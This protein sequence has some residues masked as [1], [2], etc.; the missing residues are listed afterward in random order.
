MENLL[1]KTGLRI[2]A[3]YETPF[4]NENGIYQD[5]TV[6]FCRDRKGKLWAIAGHSH[7]GHIGMFCG[8][9]LTDLREVYPISLNFCVGHADYAFDRIP[10]PEGVKARGSIWPFGLYLCPGTGRFFCFFHNETGWNGKSTAYD[11]LGPCETPHFDSDFRHIGLMHSDDEGATWTFDRWIL[12][13]EEACFTEKYNPGAG[14]ALG[15]REGVIGLGSGD[16]TVYDDLDGEYLYLLYNLIHVD[17]RGGVW[18]SCD[19][20]IARTRKRK[21]GI[22]GD[23][24]KYYD[25]SFCEA[26]NLGKETPIVRNAWHSR[27]CFSKEL[28]AY[29]M[30]SSPVIPDN[31]QT[32]V[33]DYLELRTSS[34]LLSWSEPVPVMKDGKKF[35]SHYHTL[36]SYLGRGEPQKISGGQFTL[37]CG[38][39]GTDVRAFDVEMNTF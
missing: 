30:A 34:D 2:G 38:H 17:M 24:V 32:V 10:Y 16:F 12:S 13:A 21:D 15:Q 22:M 3:S 27:V 37:L 8:N 23:F 19:T 1:K 28:N 39:N 25:G 11:S 31:P 7:L 35:G 5:G 29:L 6:P 20:C 9:D 18:K 33:A 4:R 26:G 36:L 14:R